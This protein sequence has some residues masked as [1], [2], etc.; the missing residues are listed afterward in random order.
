MQ[1]EYADDCTG[2]VGTDNKDELQVAAY[3]LLKGFSRFSRF[4]SANGLKLKEKK[5]HIL[6]ITKRLKPS[7][8]KHRSR[9]WSSSITRRATNFSRR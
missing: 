4:D 6:V 5:C 2:I 3:K 7:H 1:I 9:R 8:N